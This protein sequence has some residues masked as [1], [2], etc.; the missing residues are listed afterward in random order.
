M[1]RCPLTEHHCDNHCA[2]WVEEDVD[3]KCMIVK[4]ARAMIKGMEEL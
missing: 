3:D 2:W 4:L 1:A